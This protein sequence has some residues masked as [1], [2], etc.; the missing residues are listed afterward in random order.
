MKKIG[1]VGGISWVSTVD[2]YTLIN[3][4]VN[5][6]L[7]GLNAAEIIIYSINFA[8]LQ[9]KTW[10]NAYDLLYNACKSLK[11]AGVEAIALGA[12]T[13]HL[14][15]TQL[16]N[17]LQLPFIHIV[18][19][20][21]HTIKKLGLETIG[22]LGTK[23]TMELGFYQEIL[24]SNG[25]KV[26]TPTTQTERD[27][28]QSVVKNELGKGIVN[29]DSKKAFVEIGNE[30]IRN[31]AQGIILGCTEIPLLLTQDDFSVPVFDTTKI[32]VNAIVQYM[33]S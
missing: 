3:Q 28:V 11:D 13:A 19:E 1:L 24:H 18:A 12:N 22:L 10:T 31:G 6:I 32:H 15:A 8:E 20:T 26:L 21:A 17:A 16:E 30:L 2:Y 9:E 27:Y 33:L 5:T 29:E 25:L 23:F 4:Q 7:G 14:Y